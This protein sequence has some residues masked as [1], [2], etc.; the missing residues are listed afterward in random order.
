MIQTICTF[1]AYTLLLKT[2][3]VNISKVKKLWVT[4]LARCGARALKVTFDPCK[5]CDFPQILRVLRAFELLTTE[6]VVLWYMDL[7]SEFYDHRSVIYDLWS[8]NCD[9]WSDFWGL[10]SEIRIFW[11]CVI[12]ALSLGSK[13]SLILL[14]LTLWFRHVYSHYISNILLTFCLQFL[15]VT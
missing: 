14:L 4:F 5:R 11:E 15:S 8:S 9:L 7:W 2:Y 12:L 10:W 13:I 6:F 1:C 3:L